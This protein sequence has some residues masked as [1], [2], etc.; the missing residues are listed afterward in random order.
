MISIRFYVFFSIFTHALQFQHCKRRNAH[1][2]SILLLYINYNK[3][4]SFEGDKKEILK[5]MFYN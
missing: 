1:S 4:H 3:G 2:V 5:E